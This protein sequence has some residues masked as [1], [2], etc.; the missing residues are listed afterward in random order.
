MA[1]SR[2][3]PTNHRQNLVSRLATTSES[4]RTLTRLIEL[5]RVQANAL[6][7][8]KAVEASM[9]S[10]RLKELIVHHTAIVHEKDSLQVDNE[11]LSAELGR[12]QAENTTHAEVLDQR[13]AAF[14]QTET[15]I[16][17]ELDELSAEAHDALDVR[18][19]TCHTGFYC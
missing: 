13:L 19:I 8:Q 16:Y 2:A 10:K 12:L 5:F 7:S 4:I 9:E 14:H 6:Q 18:H 1:I 3:Q 17:E 15:A 11:R